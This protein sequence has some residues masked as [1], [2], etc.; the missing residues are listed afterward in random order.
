MSAASS[1]LF[2][3]RLEPRGL[4]NR[5]FKFRDRLVVISERI[6]CRLP[7]GLR[8]LHGSS[9]RARLGSS[10][11]AYHRVLI[12]THIQICRRAEMSMA[13]NLLRNLDVPGCVEDSLSQSVAA[14]SPKT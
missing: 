1:G 13:E 9:V 3:W 10:Q 6:L 4:I 14:M 5:A 11:C 12:D 7:R 2:L 8:S